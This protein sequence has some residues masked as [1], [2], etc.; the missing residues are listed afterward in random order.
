MYDTDKDGLVNY[1]E[2][3]AML[4][5]QPAPAREPKKSVSETQSPATYSPAR[6]H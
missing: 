1:T 2:F 6:I 3:A 4:F 5:E